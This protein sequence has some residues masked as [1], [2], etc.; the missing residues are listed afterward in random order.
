MS[1]QEQLAEVKKLFFKNWAL[2]ADLSPADLAATIAEMKITRFKPGQVIIKQG[3][4]GDSFFIILAGSASVSVTREDDWELT[5]ATLRQGTTFGEMSILAGAPRNA[6]VRA[7]ETSVMIEIE[8]KGF[9]FLTRKSNVFK[10][11]MDNLYLSRGLATHLR[12]TPIFALLSAEIIEKLISEAKLCIHYPDEIICRQGDP[13][14]AFLLLK[15]GTLQI[16][17]KE[18]ASVVMAGQGEPRYYGHQGLVNGSAWDIS[19]RA[20]TR[21]EMVEIARERLLGLINKYAE[22]KDQFAEL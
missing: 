7:I 19:L 8:R 3:E 2:V 13:V 20:C 4:M 16:E 5:V 18:S 10:H 11:A 12:L 15:D 21:V 22:L 17:E 9:D 1:E 6:T 14:H